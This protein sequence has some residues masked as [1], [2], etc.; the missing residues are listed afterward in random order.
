MKLPF[1]LHASLVAGLLLGGLVP[2]QTTAAPAAP[3]LQQSEEGD[4]ASDPFRF[5]RVDPAS[6]AVDGSALASE[7]MVYALPATPVNLDV[8]PGLEGTPDF[9]AVLFGESDDPF[10]SVA[11][12]EPHI[13]LIPLNE[14]IARY[15]A[16]G[17][18]TV[19]GEVDRLAELLAAR[20]AAPEGPLPFLPIPNAY[21]DLVTQV[22]YIDTELFRGVRFVGRFSQ[23]ASPVTGDRLSY[24]FQGFSNDGKFLVVATLPVTTG[25]VPATFEEIAQ[26]D[27]DAAFNDF[28]AYFSEV[29]T[30][31]NAAAADDFSPGLGD[32]DQLL[33]SLIFAPSALDWETLANLSYLSTAQRQEG[34][35][36][37]VP[38][39]LVAGL[40]EDIE[41]MTYAILST[42]A[43]YGAVEGQEAAALLL[44][45]N[46][47]GSGIFQSLVLVVNGEEG[48][49]NVAA[50][51]L[52]DRVAVKSVTFAGEEI[53]VDMITQGP[54]DPMCCPTLNVIQRYALQEGEL[55]LIS[56][57]EMGAVAGA[58]PFVRVDPASVTIEAPV[59]TGEPVVHLV[60]A[61]PVNLEQPPS[62]E[63]A[64]DFVALLF[65]DS[66]NALEAIAQDEPYVAIIPAAEW[67]ARWESAGSAAVTDIWSYLQNVLDE[68]PVGAGAPMPILPVPAAFN[69]VA[70]KVEYIDTA[71]LRSVRFVGRLV[72]DASP[73]T[74]EQLRY[75]F[76]AVSNDGAFVIVAVLPL[77]TELLPATFAEVPDDVADAVNNAFG[78]YMADTMALLEDAGSDDFTPS[79]KALDT[80]LASLAFAPS[81]LNQ[82]TLDNLAYFSLMGEPG[83]EPK[84]VQLVNG[85]YEDAE[86]GGFARLLANP[87]GYGLLNE[88]ESVALVLAENG[89]GSGTF[90][91][92]QVVVN[93]ADGPAVVAFAGL[94][95]RVKVTAVTIAGN[96]IIVEMI[97]Q[98]ED[99]PFCCPT[100]PVRLVYEL[101]DGELVLVDEVLDERIVDA[102]S[103]L[104]GQWQWV[105]TT[106]MDGGVVIAPEE[107]PFVLTVND[108]TTVSLTTDC[109]DVIGVVTEGG[110]GS[111]SFA[112]APRG[113]DA[114][115]EGALQPAFLEQLNA[116]SSYLF[117]A[118]D[119]VLV[120][121]M[122]GPIIR[123]APVAG[124]AGGAPDGA[125]ANAEAAGTT[126]A[127]A[128]AL[129]GTSWK[130]VRTLS[131]D[132]AEVAPADPMQFI[133]AFVGDDSFGA[134][135]DCNNYGGSFT[136]DGS[137]LQFAVIG[138][139]AMACDD[140][141]LGEQY[142]ADLAT[143]EQFVVSDGLLQITTGG[144]GPLMEFSP[145]G[146]E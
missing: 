109:F 33:E 26:D 24:F 75:F 113:V 42:P 102:P 59:M 95:D 80:M 134:L 70:V 51:L 86:F 41:N 131:A 93:G 83:G 27:L 54:D 133:L 56:S 90:E 64:P 97:T 88:Q 11:F 106:M 67:A 62:I 1:V 31:L 115:A 105:D 50:T 48:P 8:P 3:V 49:V 61:T 35:S 91:S 125:E 120:T 57:E 111:V 146:G 107:F 22:S 81:A 101:Q 47:G 142:I 136:Q 10:T 53:V 44:E 36:A 2:V 126:P 17:A 116:V 7:P 122:D 58:T 143:A 37:P 39:P 19:A 34:Q 130:W 43:G 63:G 94:G 16:A 46:T 4:F 12:G 66:S 73:I 87:I 30:Q 129:A 119:L 21:N 117:D 20:P 99:D 100:Q 25:L 144:D 127:G 112:A 9:T 52:G 89:G 137:Q 40:Y 135:T 141:L 15:E 28:N 92:L 82:T 118:G 78:N 76:Q 139:T 32:L 103:P 108:D 121:P 74:S 6:V 18:T 45:E 98:A 124:D 23:D 123:L 132:G 128:P 29:V 138:S 96:Q 71:L 69:D 114:C 65:G 60:P 55:R 72:Q 13:A 79:L 110:N 145:V 14:Y 140:G 84:M 68:H 5:V 77:S 104:L 38:V 85:A